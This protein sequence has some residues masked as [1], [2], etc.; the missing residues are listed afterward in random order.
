MQHSENPRS[1]YSGGFLALFGELFQAAAVVSVQPF[2]NVMYDYT[3][4]NRDNYL[5]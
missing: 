5:G 4:H 2:A 3:C 1:G